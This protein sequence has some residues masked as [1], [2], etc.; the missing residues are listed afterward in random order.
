MKRIKVIHVVQ[1]LDV[2]GLERL[3]VDALRFFDR[4][5]FQFRVCCLSRQGVLA[6]DLKSQGIEVVFLDKGEGL[7][8]KLRCTGVSRALILS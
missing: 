4:D 7:D 6:D 2:G 8:F 1:T 3:I 5:K